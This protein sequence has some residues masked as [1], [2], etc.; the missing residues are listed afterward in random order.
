[1]FQTQ[2]ISP[3][4]FRF[5][6]SMHAKIILPSF[7]SSWSEKSGKTSKNAPSVTGGQGAVAFCDVFTGSHQIFVEKH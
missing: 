1:M 7:G 3:L 2:A 4:T 6:I 5:P